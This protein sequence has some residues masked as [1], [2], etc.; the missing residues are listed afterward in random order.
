MTKIDQTFSNKYLQKT[1]RTESLSVALSPTIF[2]YKIEKQKKQTN[3]I[4]K[5]NKHLRKLDEYFYIFIFIFVIYI[6]YYIFYLFFILYIFILFCYYFI[7]ILFNY[8]AKI[9]KEDR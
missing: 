8:L 5:N 9:K 6:F 2:V 1:V 4:H 7:F 3:F